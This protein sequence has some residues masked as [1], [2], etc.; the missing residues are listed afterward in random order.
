MTVYNRPQLVLLNTLLKLG[1]NDWSDGEIVV[2]NDGSRIPYGP[3][4]ESFGDL[5]VKWV[6]AKPFPGCYSLKGYNNPAHAWNVGL[7]ASSGEYVFPMS[8]DIMVTPGI[9]HRA[10]NLDLDKVAWMPSVV[11][12]DTA[13]EYLGPNRLA[14]LGWFFGVHRKHMEAVGW[15]EEYMNG[16]AFEDNDMMARLALEVGRFVV[17]VGCTVWHQSHPQTAYS[18][19]LAGWTVNRG[20]CKEKWGGFIPWDKGCTLKKMVTEVNNQL[21]LDVTREEA[22]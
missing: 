15:D 17:D 5:P 21:V 18:D 20:Y 8:S 19:N 22:A 3:L 13:M 12:M 14:P 2:V 1:P 16:I 6:E 10:L 11:D 9:I 7:A 4:K